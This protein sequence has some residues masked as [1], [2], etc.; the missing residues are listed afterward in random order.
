MPSFGG[1]VKPSVQCR[2]FAHVKDPY[3][4]RGSRKLYAKLN[5][6]FPRPHFPPS[7]TEISHVGGR[8][9]PLEMTGGTKSS[10]AQ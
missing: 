2:S 7:L 3:T 9:A 1:E 8:G 5:R 4:Y 10:G 6:P